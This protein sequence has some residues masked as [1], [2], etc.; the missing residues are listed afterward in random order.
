[1]S[2]PK[3]QVGELRMTIHV[4]RKETGSVEEYQLTAPID[5]EQAKQLNIPQPEQAKE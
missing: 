4:T 3:G 2:D 5:A 1:M